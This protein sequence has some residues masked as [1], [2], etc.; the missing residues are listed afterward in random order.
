MT[1]KC[2]CNVCSGHLEFDD[3]DAGKKITCPHCQMETVLYV[4][5]VT[6]NPP[7]HATPPTKDAKQDVATP[8]KPPETK[9]T[10]A[11]TKSAGVE[12]SAV[13][14]ILL[15]LVLLAIGYVVAFLLNEQ[16]KALNRLAEKPAAPRWEYKIVACDD[17]SHEMEKYERSKGASDMDAFSAGER[18]KGQF[19]LLKVNPGSEWDMCAWF[20]EPTTDHPKLILIFKTP[21]R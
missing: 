14:S 7:T 15:L 4:P 12:N 10:S 6:A 21:E 16:V 13:L 19:S 5:K 8:P 11:P 2:N 9:I 17:D 3:A 18:F 20:M 1:T